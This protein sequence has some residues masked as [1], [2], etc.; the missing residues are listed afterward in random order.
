MNT[1]EWKCFNCGQI[2]PGERI[3]CLKCHVPKAE[4]SVPTTNETMVEEF[5]LIAIAKKL[6]PLWKQAIQ[7]HD[8]G[9]KDLAITDYLKIIDEYPFALSAHDNLGGIYIVQEKLDL[10]LNHLE[11]ALHPFNSNAYVTIGLAYFFKNEID[12]SIEYLKKAGD[13]K[14]AFTNLCYVYS[15]Q[16]KYDQ[17]IQAGEKAIVSDPTEPYAY[18]NLIKAYLKAGKKERAE[19]I[20]NTATKTIDEKLIDAKIVINRYIHLLICDEHKNGFVAIDPRNGEMI[21]EK[22]NLKSSY[23]N[24]SLPQLPK[25]SVPMPVQ[26]PRN[27]PTTLSK[28]KPGLG[29]AIFSIVLAILGIVVP[30][31]SILSILSSALCLWVILK[32]DRKNAKII[33]YIGLAVNIIGTILLILFGYRLS[34]FH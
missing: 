26:T 17:A 27:Q 31:C 33:S 22:G 20:F 34:F 15:D 10:A 13:G 4:P 28:N 23:K 12:K 30:T 16:G 24:G 3:S 19:T 18:G 11:K 2:N 32:T 14:S 29:L 6:L 25:I 5:P 9:K 21:V 8:M 7:E 1:Q